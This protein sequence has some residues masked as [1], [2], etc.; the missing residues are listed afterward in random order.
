MKFGSPMNSLVVYYSKTGNTKRLP[1]QSLARHAP[2]RCPSNAE[3]RGRRTKAEREI[4]A[5]FLSTAVESTNRADIVFVGTPTE[6]RRPHPTVMEFVGR[7]T[8]NRAAIFCT[9]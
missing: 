3:K 5:R 1:R 4:E 8:T 9:Y 7:V 6:F 2:R